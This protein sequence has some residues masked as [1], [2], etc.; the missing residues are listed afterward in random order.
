MKLDIENKAWLANI[1][2]SKAKEGYKKQK[3]ETPDNGNWILLF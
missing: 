3:I 1:I 2:E